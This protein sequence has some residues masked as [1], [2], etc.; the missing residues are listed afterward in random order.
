MN[1]SRAGK[2]MK[3]QSG[4]SLVE[5]VVVIVILGI[6]AAAALPK[7]LEVTD[8]AKKASVEGVAGGFATAVLSARA[9][10]E[11]EGRPTNTGGQNVVTYDGVAFLLTQ[12]T[13]GST[14]TGFR[15]GYPIDIVRTG[16]AATS[17]TDTS[18][19]NLMEE[20]LQ[21]PPVVVLASADSTD[22]KYTAEAGGSNTCLYSQVGSAHTFTY[23][24]TTGRVTVQLN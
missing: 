21:N 12:S 8:E 11:A 6:L 3:K 19:L 2:S 22:A 13:S 1:K 10:W 5:L 4:F 16:A 18:C 20:L 17:V 14:S 15:D 9:Q 23:D 7:F 24:V